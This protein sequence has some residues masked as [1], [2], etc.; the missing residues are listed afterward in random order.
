MLEVSEREEG[1][2]ALYRPIG[3]L[4]NCS[5]LEPVPTSLL[6]DDIAT[7]ASG[8]VF[9]LAARDILYAPSHSTYHWVCYTSTR[10]SFMRPLTDSDPVTHCTMYKMC[11]VPYQNDEHC[12]DNQ[13]DEI[14]Q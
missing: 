9:Q 1:V 11:P 5:G 2:V 13:T 12:I 3:P 8:S 10:H 7:A 6:S 4:K 14:V